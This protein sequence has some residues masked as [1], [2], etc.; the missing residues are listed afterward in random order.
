MSKKERSQLQDHLDKASN[1]VSVEAISKL[2]LARQNALSELNH[3]KPIVKEK[4]SF[5]SWPSLNMPISALSLCAVLAIGSFIYFDTKSGMNTESILL[6]NDLSILSED[7]QLL[8]DLEFY[9]WMLETDPL[10][11]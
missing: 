7:L 8:E 11:S 4:T 6:T 9:Q 5:Y 2:Q 3:H 1:E 10:D